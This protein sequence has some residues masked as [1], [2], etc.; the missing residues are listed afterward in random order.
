[1]GG[2]AFGVDR[3]AMS[4]AEVAQCRPISLASAIGSGALGFGGPASNQY[5]A[6]GRIMST[7]DIFTI[8]AVTV[9]GF[10]VI[11]RQTNHGPEQARL[12][13]VDDSVVEVVGLAPV[14]GDDPR[15]AESAS[16]GGPHL[17]LLAYRTPP[18]HRHRHRHRRDSMTIPCRQSR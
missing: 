8:S 11:S 15:C 6:I 5:P 9:F 7:E 10:S 4:G 12:D 13:G 2:A 1:M 17:E 3:V 18:S 16:A 14:T